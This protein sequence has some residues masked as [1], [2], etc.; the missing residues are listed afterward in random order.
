MWVKIEAPTVPSC[1]VVRTRT[2]N[3]A[4]HPNQRGS[5]NAGEQNLLERSRALLSGYKEPR[6]GHEAVN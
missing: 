2:V 4:I 5:T 3:S 6:V 1:P